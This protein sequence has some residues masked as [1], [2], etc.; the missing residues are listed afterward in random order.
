MKFHFNSHEIHTHKENL[1]KKVDVWD[2]QSWNSTPW[3]ELKEI[4]MTLHSFTWQFADLTETEKLSL[5]SFI[6]FGT[7]IALV[8]ILRIWGLLKECPREE[9]YLAHKV[10]AMK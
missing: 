3:S 1:I 8:R 6:E 2:L 7:N 10:K 4:E 9:R 5:I